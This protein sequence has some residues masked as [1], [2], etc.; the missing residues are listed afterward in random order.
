MTNPTT[1][2]EYAALL[3]QLKPHLVELEERIMSVEYGSIDL[4]IEV[5]AGKAVKM[6]FIEGRTWLADK[7]A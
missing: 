7:N 2:E 4:R 1:P 3:R 5:R 6:T